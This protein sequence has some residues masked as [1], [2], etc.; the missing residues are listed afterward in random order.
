MTGRAVRRHAKDRAY[1][2]RRRI[3]LA[4]PS[5]YTEQEMTYKILTWHLTCHCWGHRSDHKIARRRAEREWRRV[6]T[7]ASEVTCL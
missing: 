4:Y 5:S 1:A 3:L 2:R 7:T 6:E